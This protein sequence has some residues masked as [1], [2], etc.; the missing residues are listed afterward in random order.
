MDVYEAL[1]TTRAMR[2]LKPD[3]IPESVQAKILDAAIRAPTGGNSQNWRFL[4]VDD[5][6]LIGQLGEIYQRCIGQLWVTFYKERLDK[7]NAN[8]ELPESIADLKMQRSA[9]HLADNFADVPLLLFGFAEGDGSGGSIFPAIW[10]AQLAA[11]AEGVG[12]SLTQAMV[13]ELPLVKQLL[14]VPEESAW[15]MSACVT[16]GYPTGRWGV[17]ARRPAHEVA[18]RNSW[19][20]PLGFEINEPLWP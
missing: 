12:T 15:I 8:P 4:L 1:Y 14:G 10:S 11:R 19:D 9:Q 16:F 20:G 7:A 18:F 5:K 3:P 17:G 13:F 6:A 2:R